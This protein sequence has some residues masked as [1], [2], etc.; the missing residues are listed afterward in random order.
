MTVKVGKPIVVGEVLSRSFNLLS[1]TPALLIPQAIVLVLSLLGDIASASTLSGLGLI[2]VFVN[3]VVSIIVAGAY[4]SMV[5]AALGGGQPS[6]THSLRQAAG[7]FWTLLAAGILVGLIVVL[8][9]I[10]LI[11]PGIIFV[12]WYAYTVPAVML[13]N[14][15]ALQGMSASKAFGRDKK[16]STF[17]LFLVF[18]VVIIVVSVLQAVLSLGSPLL[19]HVVNSILLV[20]VDAWIAVSLTYAYLTYGPMGVPAV[21]EASAIGGMPSAPIVQQAPQASGPSPRSK[22]FCRFCGSPIEPDSKFCSSCG[23]PI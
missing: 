21:S 19:G 17:V 5:Q 14:K 3:L 18:G 4:P 22:R 20:P 2:L 8:G 6:V 15:G 11:I 1:R 12:T 10:A 7:R 13:E 16:G 9:F 23:Q